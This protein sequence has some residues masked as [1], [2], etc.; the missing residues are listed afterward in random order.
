MWCFLCLP[1]IV[2]GTVQRTL[3][4]EVTIDSETAQGPPTPCYVFS[5][6]PV[7]CGDIC[8]PK[9]TPSSKRLQKVNVLI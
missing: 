7:I 3:F 1:E 9:L 5:I 2:K 6:L 4:F 8:I